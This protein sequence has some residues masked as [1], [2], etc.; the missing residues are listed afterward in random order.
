MKTLYLIDGH[1]QFFRAFHAIRTP[2]SSPVTKEPT[3]ATFGFVGMLLKLFRQYK[4]DYVAVAIDVSGDRETFRS[5]IYPEYKATRTAPPETL[6]PQ[7]ERCVSILRELGIPV[8]FKE[9]FEAD[10]VIATLAGRIADAGVGVRIVSKDKDLKQLLR[11]PGGAGFQ[12][13]NSAA[14]VA[15]I[16][17]FDIHTD[18]RID[19]A[20]LM[21]EQGIR[22]DQVIDMLTLMGDSVD[23]VPGVDGVG[24][25]TAAE[26]IQ[27]YGTLDNLIAHAAEIKG[28]RGEKLREAIPRLGLS[29]TL[30]AL[31]HD[32]PVEL[33]LESAAVGG[34]HIAKLIP[35]CKELGFNRY[36]DEVKALLGGATESTSGAQTASP[37]E[38]RAQARGQHPTTHDADSAEVSSPAPAKRRSKASAD[39]NADGLFAPSLFS[40]E[41]TPGSAAAADT[42]AF[43]KAQSGTYRCIRTLSELR[44][45][46]NDIRAARFFAVDTETTGLSPLRDK[47]CGVCL[48][49]RA[50]EGVYVPVRSPE[51]GTHLD[52]AT[53][54][55]EL[56]PVLEDSAITKCG[57]NLK[58][59]LLVLRA[60]GVE[61]NLGSWGHRL[62]AGGDAGVRTSQD[63][64]SNWS[65]RQHRLEAGATL[66]DASTGCFAFDSMVASYLIDASRSGHGMDSLALGLLNRTNISIKELLGPVPT[67][68]S[69]TK[70]RTFDQVPLDLATEY[71]AEDADVTV[72][73]HDVMSPQLREMRLQ[74]LF[75]DVE[76]PLVG[77]LA[78][79]EWNGIRVEPEELERQRGRLESRIKGLADDILAAAPRAFN[80]DSPKQLAEILF[81][82]PGDPEPGLGLKPGKKLK[83]GYSTD[84]EVLEKLAN[85][86]ACTSRVPS[87][88]LEYRQLTK[89]VNTYLVALREAINPATGR[90][91][92][93]F[94]QTVAA[95]GRLASSDPN[96]QNI[97]IRT[98]IGREIRKAFV[99]EPGHVLISADYS[100]IELRIL[101]HLS[102]DPALKEAF[103]RGEDI[104]T[105]V[106]A[107]VHGVPIEQ[108]SKEQRSGAKMVNFGIVYG[109]TPFGLARRLGV[110]NGEAE[111]IITGYK[112]KFAGITTFLQECVD[113]AQRHGYVETIL[114]RRRP[115]QG[116]DSPNPQERALAERTSINS[117]VQGSAADLIKVAMVDIARHIGIRRPSPGGVPTSGLGVHRSLPWPDVRMLLQIHD[118]LVFECPESQAPA[119]SAFVVERMESAMK[120]S[121][122]LKVDAAWGRTWFEG[123]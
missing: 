20:Q 18:L 10:D 66:D 105:A 36:Q 33:P 111:Q 106:A 52:E 44:S 65:H 24:P 1:A 12:P 15:P 29:K 21:A 102:G 117:V 39:D 121:V 45:V 115:I 53:V 104:H 95:T 2:M 28:K 9:G 25:K 47:L 35:I 40:A 94:H 30:I 72:Q 120:L 83:T 6:G 37:T 31:R 97:P 82:K 103:E 118:E 27:Q 107:Q 4:P 19:P 75:D 14:T 119:A 55:G 87:L 112:R 38:L 113:F 51:P 89:L 34:F 93:S 68:A 43:R 11:A 101:A 114:K 54:L 8:V 63:S 57:H 26:L 17:L 86:P 60:A 76:M 79:L 5:E 81:N 13:A 88:I 46:I 69:K 49:T 98:E 42:P 67:P 80:P 122:P 78:D 56:R 96:L 73:L 48:S 110:S 99:P 123:K 71:A 23:N 109:V 64:A 58:F 7:I 22:P 90:I 92:A 70:Q 74:S 59:D 16:E 100:Q 50:G 84:I 32:V 108:V 91:H 77:V 85:D 3:N 61:V 41:S 62:P 116:I